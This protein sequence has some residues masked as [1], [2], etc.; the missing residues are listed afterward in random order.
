MSESPNLTYVR[1]LQLGDSTRQQHAHAV[2]SGKEVRVANGVYADA[3]EWESADRITRYRTCIDAVAQTRASE[4]IMSH[5][6]A[7]ALH[8]ID[9]LGQWPELVHMTQQPGI[10]T[11]SSGMI[12]RHTM[13][14]REDEVVEVDGIRVTSV[15][16]TLVD[17]A[18]RV[19]LLDA[20]VSIDSA[21]HV[22]R[23]SQA[24]PMI[25]K[26]ELLA[27]LGSRDPFLGSAC[28]LAAIGFGE[29]GAD[30]AIESVSRVTMSRLSCPP[31]VL[32]VSYRDGGGLIGEC[33][34]SW[35][36]Y[37]VVGEA[38]GERK[39]LDEAYRSGRSVERVVLDEKYREDRLRAIPLGVARWN[40]VT[41]N[42][43]ILLA[44]KL[45]SIGL[46][47]LMPGTRR[48]R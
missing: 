48:R 37:G 39:Y 29:S 36:E 14:F 18:A 11:R 13:Q 26:G 12:A 47:V 1:D 23:R 6:S 21:L 34:F 30:T 4:P 28:A 35:P 3:E 33:D 44:Q 42:S 19:P 22:A 8:G 41:A 9:I 38:D 32:Q 2:K 15:A 40:W 17:I 45:L 7:L 27:Y 24:A 46:P 31:P 16:R 5:W 10:G 20:V 43:P 25:E